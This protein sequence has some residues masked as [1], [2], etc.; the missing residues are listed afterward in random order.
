[1][2]SLQ[3]NHGSAA[4]GGFRAATAGTDQ[5]NWHLQDGEIDRHRHGAQAQAGDGHRV[6]RPLAGDFAEP[7][8]WQFL[9]MPDAIDRCMPLVQ[10]RQCFK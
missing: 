8:H 5:R 7:W 2:Q 9:G 3:G 6:K 1:M 4:E 10:G